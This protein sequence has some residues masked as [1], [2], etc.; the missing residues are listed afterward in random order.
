MS[1]IVKSKYC[2]NQ[3]LEDIFRFLLIICV[4]GH[5]HL[6]IVFVFS[7]VGVMIITIFRALV[8]SADV[9]PE[10]NFY[11]RLYTDVSFF[12]TLKS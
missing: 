10:N 5:R 12:E 2:G 7:H 8:L 1:T 3:I 4:S 11:A 9:K 6:P